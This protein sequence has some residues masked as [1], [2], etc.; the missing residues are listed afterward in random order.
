M[1][2]LQHR[3][4]VFSVMWFQVLGSSGINEN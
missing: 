4:L 3:M 1:P 2:E